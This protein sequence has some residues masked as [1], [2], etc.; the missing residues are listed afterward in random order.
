MGDRVLIDFLYAVLISCFVLFRALENQVNRF[1]RSIES[2]QFFNT[3]FL[4]F[5]LPSPKV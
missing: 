2:I 1:K 3:P 4:P 5:F